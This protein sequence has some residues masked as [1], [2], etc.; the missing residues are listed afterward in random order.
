ML[1]ATF[2]PDGNLAVT[3]SW[4]KTVRIWNAATY[5]PLVTLSDHSEPV[6]NVAFSRDG[7]YIVTA[8]RD[9]TARIYDIEKLTEDSKNTAHGEILIE[10]AEQRAPRCLDKDERLA[11]FL[12]PDPPA[13]CIELGKWPY[14]NTTWRGWLANT[15]S[16]LKL[17][18]PDTVDWQTWRTNH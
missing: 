5:N 10:R 4:D 13:W 2:S 17:P 1:G 15:R 7:R 14:D 18:R 16:G 3:A 12:D 11:V 8:S 6:F 9:K